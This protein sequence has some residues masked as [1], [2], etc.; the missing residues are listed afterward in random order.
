MNGDE[1]SNL[2]A[3]R[4]PWDVVVLGGGPAGTI[5]ARQLT[6]NGYHVLLVDKSEFPRFKVCGGCLGGAALDVLEKV[7]LGDLPSNCGGIP[8]K[9]MRLASGGFTAEFEIGR[10]IAVS[11]QAFDA[12]LIAEAVHSGTT[13]CTETTG[14]LQLSAETDAN[15]VVLRRQKRAVVVATKV[16]VVATGLAPSPPG[17]YTH[18]GAEIMGWSGGDA[19][20]CSRARRARDSSYVVGS[21]RICGNCT[22]RK[23]PTG[24]RSRRRP[25]SINCS[26]IAGSTR[27]T[28]FEKV[29]TSDVRGLGNSQMARHSAAHEMDSAAGFEP[30]LDCG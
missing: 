27:R 2:V 4:D 19:G 16:V 13:L 9:K 25:S 20:E 11:R 21:R 18:V 30:L 8:L 26:Y 15:R 3:R 14:S 28:Y 24:H 1:W 29:G 5:A 12:A 6:L 17:Y 22:C 7:G 23:R 10:R